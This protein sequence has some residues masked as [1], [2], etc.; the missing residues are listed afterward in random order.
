MSKNIDQVFIANPITSNAGTDLMY[1]GQSPYGIGNDAAMTFTNFSAQFVLSALTQNHIFIGNGSNKAVASTATYPNSTTINQILYSSANNVISELVTANTS[2]LT[3]SGAGAPGFT[4][5]VST[6]GT[7]G[8]TSNIVSRDANGNSAFNNV[9]TSITNN[10]AGS[11]IILTA[12]SS[13]GQSFSGVGASSIQL[14]NATTLLN[15]TDYYINNN[16]NSTITVLLN[17]GITTLFTI[18]VGGNVKIILFSNVTTNGTWDWHW[19]FPATAASGTIYMGNGANAGYKFSTATYPFTTTINQLLYS[20]SANVITGLPTANNGALVTDAT[21]VPSILVGPGTTGHFL[22]SNAA[23]APSWSTSTIT[24]GGNFTMSGGFTFTGTLTNNTSVTFPTS[25]TLATS[26]QIINWNNVT[27]SPIL[28]VDN[29]GYI[30]NNGAALVT[31]QLPTT[32]PIG[33]RFIV[34]GHDSGGWKITQ[35][36]ASQ[37]I[38]LGNLTSTT[39][40]TGFI[41][42]TDGNDCVE[43][44]CTATDNE[45]TVRSSMGN[46]T[47]F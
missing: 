36:N 32:S 24:L 35:S 16:T 37:H 45:F 21:G 25:G 15:N 44:I 46:I 19:F 38:H 41:A 31:L 3:T 42:S 14:P 11:S 8:G 34:V 9:I 47:I 28:L 18:P 5:Y 6:G 10:S 40:L 26:T 27:S 4:A 33:Q 30:I 20:S 17:D 1:F 39:G 22:Q 29:N 43:L 12:A 23:A 13:Q 2:V 7:Y